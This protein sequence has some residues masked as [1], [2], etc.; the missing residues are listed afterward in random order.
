MANP[1]IPP[2][3]VEVVESLDPE[4]ILERMADLDRQRDAL[5]VL[6]RAAR[7]RRRKGRGMPPPAEVA[8]A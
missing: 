8:N 5:L 1:E 3:L 2:D 4:A 7:A 6:L